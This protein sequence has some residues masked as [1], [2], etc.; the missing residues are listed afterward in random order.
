MEFDYERVVD[1]LDEDE[2]KALKWYVQNN[3]TAIIKE[4]EK[5]DQQIELIPI[6]VVTNSRIVN[7]SEEYHSFGFVKENEKIIVELIK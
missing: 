7:S 4:L 6:T 2:Y 1:I 3:N 5:L